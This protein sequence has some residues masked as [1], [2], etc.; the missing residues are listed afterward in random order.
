MRPLSLSLIGALLLSLNA[1]PALAQDAAPPRAESAPPAAPAHPARAL[2]MAKCFQCHTEAMWRDQ[3]LDARGWEATLY[4][5]V[6]RGAVWS[7]DDI[8]A[9]AGFLSTDFGPG[10]PRSAL[11]PEAGGGRR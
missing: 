6:A 5:M 1:G 10:V 7:G 9:M 8:K 11:S 2:T 3:R 4:R